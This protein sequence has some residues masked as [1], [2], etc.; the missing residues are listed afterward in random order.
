MHKRKL[1]VNFYNHVNKIIFKSAL[2]SGVLLKVCL[3]CLML[4][5]RFNSI[6]R[7]LF[8]TST[9]P[10]SKKPLIRSLLDMHLINMIVKIR[11]LCYYCTTTYLNLCL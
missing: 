4:C 11:L 6:A 2:I 7:I 9:V 5:A 1:E 8:L 10:T 3:F